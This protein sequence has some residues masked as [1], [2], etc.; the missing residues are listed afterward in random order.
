MNAS[1]VR[2]G[3][4]AIFAYLVLTLLGRLALGGGTGGAVVGLIGTAL[5]IFGFWTTKGFLNAKGHTGAD[6]PILILIGAA[7][8]TAI[9]GLFGFGGGMGGM[10]G[11]TGAGGLQAV[12]II[13]LVI[14]LVWFLAWLWFGLSALKFGA[15]G[16]GIWKAT[17]ILYIIGMAALGLMV[18]FF[19]LAA[20]A[21]AMGLVAVG[22]ILALVGLLVMLA[23][24]IVHGIGLI[25]GA[26]KM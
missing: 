12:G 14:T 19:I 22:G 11:G 16:G 5:L 6:M 23:G 21:K 9:L 18:V 17:G 7:A 13:A 4:I 24:L 10:A 8:I 3:G 2:F 25:Q 20:I 15:T 1:M 26:G